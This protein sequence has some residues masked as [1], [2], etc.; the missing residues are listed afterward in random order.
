MKATI[1]HAAEHYTMITNDEI[2]YEDKEAMI[3]F[4]PENNSLHFLDKDTHM[5]IFASRGCKSRE[6]ALKIYKKFI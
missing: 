5:K 4:H 6:H 2:F 3:V 1:D